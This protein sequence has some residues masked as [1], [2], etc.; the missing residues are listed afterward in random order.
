MKRRKLLLGLAATMLL[1]TG[2]LPEDLDSGLLVV[3]ETSQKLVVLGHTVPANGGR[4]VVTVNGCAAGGLEARMVNGNLVA[5]LSE[6]WCADQTWT[7]TGKGE[8]TLTDGK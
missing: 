6:E 3:N 2:C 8:S 5:R 7:I 1:A 4:Y